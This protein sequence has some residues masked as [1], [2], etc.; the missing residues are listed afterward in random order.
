MLG[1]ITVV[2]LGP[3]S[4]GLITMESWE[5]LQQAKTLL[6]RTA[7]HPTVEEIRRR[8]VEIVSYDGFYE[9][10]ESFE[11]LYAA[12]AADLIRRARA[13]EEIVY[14]VPG[15]PLVA[16]RT[17]VLL[18]E[19]AAEQQVPL[20]ILPGMSFVEV[21][22]TR[23]GIDPIDGLT[24]IDAEDF[25]ALPADL[26][27]GLVIT[28]VYNGAIASDTKLSLMEVYPDDYEVIFIHNLGMPDES[29]RPIPLFEL[30]RQPDIDHLTSL[31]V[32]PQSRQPVFDLSP[33][34]D[35]MKTLRSPAAV[36]GIWPR[37][38]RAC[39]A[40]SL[41]RPMRCLRP[42]SLRMRNCSVRSSVICCSRS[43]F[44]RV[45]PRRRIVSPCRTSSMA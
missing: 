30:D 18:R 40:I 31:Y 38:I 33:L 2:G 27:T 3:G 8:G 44:M 25:D 10:A 42:S 45:W 6:F 14:A 24:I 1:N 16:E 9:Q 29:L 19:L 21:L 5:L 35:I 32:P 15:S 26:P 13:G 28:Q 11:A 20:R 23:L 22:Y 37:R 36:H 4:F 34:T 41:R 7:I 39:A 17:V 43:F 12:I